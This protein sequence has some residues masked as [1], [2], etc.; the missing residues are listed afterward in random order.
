MVRSDEIAAEKQEDPPWSYLQKK[1]Q[2][3]NNKSQVILKIQFPMSETEDPAV[4]DL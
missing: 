2:A 1:S 4:F 3:P